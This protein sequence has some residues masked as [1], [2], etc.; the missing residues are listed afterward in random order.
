MRLSQNDIFRSY[1][2]ALFKEFDTYET[3]CGQQFELASYPGYCHLH[4]II[5]RGHT[6]PT[7]EVYI[8]VVMNCMLH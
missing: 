7:L 8:Y 5:L 6:L 3:K 2:G 4:K 1:S